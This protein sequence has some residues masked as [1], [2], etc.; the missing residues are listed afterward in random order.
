LDSARGTPPQW[1]SLSLCPDDTVGS[2]MRLALIIEYQGTNYHGFQYQ[3]NV[4]SIQ[5][6]LEKA[7]I[8]FTGEALRVKGAGRTDAGV[9]AKGQV[10]AFDTTAAH[11]PATFLKALNFYLPDD[12]AVKQAYRVDESFDPRRDALRRAYR[13]VILN[14]PVPSP[15][16]RTT[17]WPVRESLDVERMSEAADL[18]VGVHDF[19]RFSGP[20]GDDAK[21][22]VRLISE[23]SVDRIED[24]VTFDVEGSSFLPHQVRR[25]TGALVDLGRGSLDLSEFR[26][27]VGG[28]DNEAVAH[29]LG[30]QGLCLMSVT[31]SDFPPR[32]GV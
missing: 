16:L 25:M 27:M 21:S 5:E 2:Q 3:S 18:L 30:P 20:L 28:E 17:T 32:D 4:P 12:V 23:A 13:Y 6:A 14:S 24:L 7:I 15:L 22:T 8:D 26:E 29:S 9:H 19:V 11:S 31:Y 1:Q 10:V